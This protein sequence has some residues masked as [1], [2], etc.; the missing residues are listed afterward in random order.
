MDVADFLKRRMGQDELQKFY[1]RLF[2]KIREI[3][4]KLNIFVTMADEGS[5]PK[6]SKGKLAGLPVSVKDCICVKGMQSSAG[7]KI[8]EGW[9]P[10]YD[11]TA[12][13][14]VKA[15]GGFIIGKTNQD[16][17]GFG[18]FCTNSGYGIPKNPWDME[19]VCGGSSGGTAALTAALDM[20]HIALAQSTGG[21]ISCP[22]AWCGVFGLT[23]TY[24]LVSRYGLI[25]YANSLDKI[26]IMARDI[27]G[28][29]VM[30]DIIAGKDKRDPTTAKAKLNKP[31]KIKRV[32]LPKEYLD[33]ADDDVENAVWDAA[34][35]LERN[36]AEC[37]EVS[38]KLLKYHIPAYYIIACSEAST[39]LAKFCGMRYGKEGVIAGDFNEYF[40]AIRGAYFGEEAKRRIILGTFARLAGYRDKYYL[41]ALQVRAEIIKEF[42]TILKH[43]DMLLSPTMPTIAPKFSEIAGLS[44]LQQYQMDIL[45]VGPNLAGLPHLNVP[46]TFHNNLPVGVHLI[47]NHWDDMLLLEAAKKFNIKLRVPNIPIVNEI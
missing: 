5:A 33:A 39:N 22:A 13:A 20:P 37:E 23:P 14:R 35:M 40:S 28:I 44:P 38:L 6:T 26:G 12:V 41:K 15:E 42:K 46:F 7:S 45:T 11:A 27:D 3:D 24:G 47:G 2:E 29:K 1:H 16:E 10:P 9:A 34:K 30:L 25:D 31:K 21:S 43:Y 32:A 17:F 4:K 8:L 19:R 18:T 36:G